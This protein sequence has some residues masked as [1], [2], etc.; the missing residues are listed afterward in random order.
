MA[1]RP[2]PRL[3]VQP[4]SY[5]SRAKARRRR[6]RL[7]NR[8]KMGTVRLL[9]RF[10][11][12]SKPFFGASLQR[13]PL[14]TAVFAF[15]ACWPRG[16]RSECALLSGELVDVWDAKKRAPVGSD[17]LDSGVRATTVARFAT[18]C[19]QLSAHPPNTLG[20]PLSAPH[21]PRAPRRAPSRRPPPCADKPRSHPKPT[22][23]RW[24]GGV[25]HPRAVSAPC[26]TQ[27]PVAAH[28]G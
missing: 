24:S 22:R 26:R 23:C 7:R 25:A 20:R 12:G 1:V 11:T 18:S 8:L 9:D 13:P 27:R 15:V 14:E 19:P 16:P 2:P 21:R 28:Q 5:R 4:I 17:S 6:N 3:S 10:R